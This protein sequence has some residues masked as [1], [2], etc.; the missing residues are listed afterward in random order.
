MKITNSKKQLTQNEISSLK[1]NN[2]SSTNLKSN[3]QNKQNGTGSYSNKQ[4]DDMLLSSEK[5]QM[6]AQTEPSDKLKISIDGSITINNDNNNKD[7]PKKHTWIYDELFIKKKIVDMSFEEEPQGENVIDEANNS[8]NQ[9]NNSHSN[10]FINIVS[11]NCYNALQNE[12]NELKKEINDLNTLMN[13][14]QEENGWVI[15]KQL[16][17]DIGNYKDIIEH[18]LRESANLTKEILDLKKRIKDTSQIEID[19]QES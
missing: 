9:C 7:K 19:N 2:K 12:I 1:P 5:Q 3:K 16:N 6:Q 14:S 8:H 15:E 4:R 17:K 11:L 10:F 13:N 18:C